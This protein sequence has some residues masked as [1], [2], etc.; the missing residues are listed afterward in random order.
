M[1]CQI[2][3][4][5][6]IDEIIKDLDKGTYR[7]GR[8]EFLADVFKCGALVRTYQNY[9]YDCGQALDWSE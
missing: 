8:H 3:D 4:I 5:P 9:C 7:V 2:K 1:N 6:T